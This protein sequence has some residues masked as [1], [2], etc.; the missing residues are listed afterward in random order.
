[1]LAARLGE[2]L[3][4]PYGSPTGPRCAENVI[5]FTDIATTSG[6]EPAGANLKYVGLP[7][8]GCEKTVPGDQIVDP[9]E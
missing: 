9:N 1:M 2:S 7:A 5:L 3:A 4:G 6:A 8:P